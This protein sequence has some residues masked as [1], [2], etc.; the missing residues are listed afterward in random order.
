M[1]GTRYS[2]PVGMPERVGS[3]MIRRIAVPSAALLLVGCGAE[4][5]APPPEVVEAAATSTA[6]APAA[7]TGTPEVAATTARP[8]RTP[9]E[10]K[11][12]TKAPRPRPRR[13][14]ATTAPSTRRGIDVTLVA[15]GD[16][17]QGGGKLVTAMDQVGCGE[18]DEGVTIHIDV[19]GTDRVKNVWF[20]YRVAT[21]TPFRGEQH[22]LTASGDLHRYHGVIGPFEAKPENAAGGTITVVAH[23]IEGQGL[24]GRERTGKGTFRLR[25]CR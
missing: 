11:A 14:T 23:V 1:I 25:P 21:K 13:S 10:P 17:L 12:T 22:D 24:E 7:T 9:A 18:D 6:G 20:T 19:D 15:R 2:P 16:P 5:A 3:R 4:A 8:R